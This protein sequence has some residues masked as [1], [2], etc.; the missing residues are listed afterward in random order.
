VA[1]TSWMSWEGG[2]DLCGA[3]RRGLAA[4]NVVLNVGR[5][6]HTPAGSAPCGMIVW[7][8]DP[9]APPALAG[10]FS[11]LIKV[12]RYFGPSLFAGTPF[13]AAGVMKAS[14]EVVVG[15]DG[16][17]TKVILGDHTFVSR[18]SGL[19]PLERIER[20]P[21][22]AT[23]FWQQALEAAAARATLEV[24]G[25]EVPLFLPPVGIG[26]GPAACW[27]PAGLYAR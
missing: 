3:T 13:E 22:A 18:L 12:G 24:D 16:V 17:G 15:R 10:F 1:M 11:P 7:Q 6:V 2:V 4:P 26:G 21:T 23:P 20:A 25:Q 27:S 19:G 9:A 8:P 5:M 14:I